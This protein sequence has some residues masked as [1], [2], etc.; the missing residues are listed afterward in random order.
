MNPNP[1]DKPVPALA[2]AFGLTALSHKANANAARELGI[3][4]SVVALLI[5]GLLVIGELRSN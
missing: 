1:L 2:L 4:V 5:G 3:P